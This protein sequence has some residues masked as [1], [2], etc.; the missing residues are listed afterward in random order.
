MAARL[1]ACVGAAAFTSGCI[2]NP[3]AEAKI[4]P[5][6]P[7]AG[8]VAKLAHSNSDYPSFSEIPA[9]PTDLRPARMYGQAARD[10]DQARVQIEQATAPGTWTLNNTETF[11]AAARAA[12]GPDVA[13]ASAADTEAFAN[14]LRKRATPPPPPNR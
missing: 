11:A 6:S 8:E 7:V 3:L 12:A 10:V 1:L 9:K 14:T 4:D 13:P 2:G 5:A